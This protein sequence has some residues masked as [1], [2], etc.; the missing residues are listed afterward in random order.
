MKL[1]I[2]AILN[3][4]SNILKPPT[5]MNRIYSLV[6]DIMSMTNSIVHFG[7]L[8]IEIN[9]SPKVMNHYLRNK[10]D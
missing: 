8:K 2:N 9:I 7:H 5:K 3:H 6:A 10:P 4:P 1:D